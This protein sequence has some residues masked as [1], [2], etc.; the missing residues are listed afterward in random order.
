MGYRIEFLAEST[1]E[2]SVRHC[3]YA[4]AVTLYGVR[5]E[6]DFGLSQMA[7][8]IDGYQIKDSSGAIVLLHHLYP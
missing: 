8:D 7:G 6:A 5:L 1:D 2:T 3:A 4:N